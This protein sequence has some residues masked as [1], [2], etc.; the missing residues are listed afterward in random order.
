[1]CVRAIYIPRAMSDGPSF[2]HPTDQMSWKRLRFK[3]A[4]YLNI[5]DVRKQICAIFT[6]YLLVIACD[7]LRSW[8]ER[9]GARF[10]RYEAHINAKN[11]AYRYWSPY[12][13][14]PVI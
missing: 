8:T 1:L 12:N 6:A 7:D 5:Y 10:L 13:L 14:T 2:D 4:A 9:D 11:Q 3:D